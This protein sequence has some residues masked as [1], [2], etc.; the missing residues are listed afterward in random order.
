MKDKNKRIVFVCKDRY[1]FGFGVRYFAVFNNG[2]KEVWR[3]NIKCDD[4]IVH[5]MYVEFIYEYYS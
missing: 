3:P 5:L 1:G 4:V 2:R